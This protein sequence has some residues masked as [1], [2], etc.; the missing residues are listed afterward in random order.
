MSMLLG[1]NDQDMEVGLESIRWSFNFASN[2]PGQ[3][4][5]RMY[6]CAEDSNTDSR[7][8]ATRWR[9]RLLGSRRI[10]A[11]SSCHLMRFFRRTD[12]PGRLWPRN[13]SEKNASLT[14]CID[15]HTC[16]GNLLSQQ[17]KK[18]KTCERRPRHLGVPAHVFVLGSSAHSNKPKAWSSNR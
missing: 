12:S 13:W 11:F 7:R 6:E 2:S 15:S 3:S 18:R 8:E 10:V 1:V 9:W 14:K 17:R 16:N 4:L 5:T